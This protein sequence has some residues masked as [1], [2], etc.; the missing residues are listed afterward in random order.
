MSD[1]H[2]LESRLIT[3]GVE[4]LALLGKHADAL[5]Q[6]YSRD[7]VPLDT[8]SDTALR[9][10]LAARIV[11]RPDDQGGVKLAP[12]VRELIAEM[13]AD[14]TRRQVNADVGETLELLRTLV[15]SYREAL[16][17]GEHWRQEQ[18]LLRLRQAVDDLNGRFADAIDSL[19]QR[20]NSDFGFVSRLNDKI[21]ENDRAQKQIVRLLDGLQLIDFNELIELVGTDGALRKL[22]ISQLQRQLSQH[23]TSLREVQSR[24]TEL[25]ARFRQ[26]QSRSRLV[27]G[28]AA[29][30]RE[31]PHFVPGNYARRSE[32]PELINQATPLT[33]AAA[34]AL[35]H[36]PDTRLLTE[37]VHELPAP[38]HKPQEV[39][40]ARP[41]EVE[42]QSLVAARQQALKQD[43]ES[44]YLAVIDHSDP[45]GISALAYLQASDME[46]GEEIWLF[47]V[48]A[49]YQGLP[50][51]EQRAFRLHQAESPASRFNDLRLIHDVTLQLAN[52][53]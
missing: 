1:D 2:E 9:R 43:V 32:V 4:R 36:E 34:P 31:H 6:G 29:F 33:A 48:I 35:D 13:L 27:S 50:R 20:L 11:W 47:Q 16:S 24:L 21:R 22:L 44:F 10:L 15:Q 3:T 26:Q 23:Y 18:Q 46:W 53:A 14:E 41:A 5:M 30:L 38:I 51:S 42:E 17:Q 8:L 28:M 7:E 40:A 52:T 12:R 49:E 25:M 19:W 39:A 37:L 45:A